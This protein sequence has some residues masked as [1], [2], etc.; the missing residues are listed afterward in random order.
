MKLP[1]KGVGPHID[2]GYSLVSADGHVVEPGDLWTTRVDTRFRDR[3][4]RIESLSD[5]DYYMLEGMP[6]FPLSVEG[7]II[8]EKITGGIEKLGGRRHS[9][10]RPGGWDPHARLADQ[11]L[12]NI[13]AE[14]IHPS[15]SVAFW[16]HPD[17]ELKRAIV[18]AYND[19]LGEYCA[20]APDRL[21]GVGLLPLAGP[22][23]VAI[24][25]AQRIA[26]KGLRSIG[27]PSTVAELPYVCREYDPLWATLQD[28]GLPVS[29]HVGT[30]KWPLFEMFSRIQR[31]EAMGVDVITSTIS[32]AIQVIAE[33]LW[34]GVPQR[35]PKLRFVI[36]EG[37]I[38]WVASLLDWMDGWWEDH[39]RW[40]EPRLEERPSFYFHR[41]FWAT[42][43]ADR[44]GILTREM[45]NVD[46]L[47]WGSDYPHTE[48]TFPRSRE[49]IAK[50]FEGVPDLEVRKIVADNTAH[51]YG[52]M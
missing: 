52:L 26:K 49:M 4:P 31:M 29:V 46:H 51:L 36:V 48:G 45:L 40:M 11:E 17:L 13:R 38:G 9:D 6:P 7:T 22:I 5:G 15:A 44:A 3:V 25:E 32:T 12:D 19:W 34:G 10:G 50:T 37:G 18:H 27:I 14:L 35:F 23:D 39:H 47:L 41:Q 30:G 24:Q 2:C 20:V 33:L 8:N 28:L 1:E 42:F 43:Q 16:G 21:L